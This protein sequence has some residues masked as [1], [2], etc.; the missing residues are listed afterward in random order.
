MSRL[1]FMQWHSE[2]TL[3]QKE[4]RKEMLT[5][6]TPTTTNTKLLDA[7]PLKLNLDNRDP[8]TVK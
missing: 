5:H 3:A 4:R 8:A 1:A 6:R 7:P 2:N